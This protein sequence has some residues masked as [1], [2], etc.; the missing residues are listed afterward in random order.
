MII[1]E[2]T[3]QKPRQNTHINKQLESL[4]CRVVILW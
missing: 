4:G 3:R 1:L 2:D